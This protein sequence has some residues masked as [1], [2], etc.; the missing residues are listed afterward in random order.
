MTRD[1]AILLALA[2]QGYSNRTIA[3]IAGVTP[4]AIQAL[5]G[6]GQRLVAGVARRPVPAMQRKF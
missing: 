3:E 2:R 1:P 6:S 4:A 5:F